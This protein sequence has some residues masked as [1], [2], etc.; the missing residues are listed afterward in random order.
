MINTIQALVVSHAHLQSI[1]EGMK[2]MDDGE[3]CQRWN[4]EFMI[5]KKMTNRTTSSDKQELLVKNNS[6]LSK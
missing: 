5:I 3:G 1:K 2:E 6:D 4:V